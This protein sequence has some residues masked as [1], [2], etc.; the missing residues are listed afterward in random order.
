MDYLASVQALDYLANKLDKNGK[1]N[2]LSVLKLLFFAERYHARKY[3]SFFTNDTFY[4][5]K[6]G[7]VPSGA[8]DIL[9]FN[10]LDPELQ[11]YYFEKI[12]KIDDKYFKSLQT[13]KTRDDY[14]DL[15]DSAM[16]SLDFAL[17]N[18]GKLTHYQLVD[19][20]HRYPEWLRFG[21]L[22]ESGASAREFINVDDYFA[23]V[24]DEND[25][26]NVIPIKAVKAN[27]DWF[28]GNF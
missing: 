23:P 27:K 20:T 26:Y 5:M 15:S 22:L 2:K 14:E 16:E 8:K 9:S 19:E 4:A 1:A 25:P 28:K 18:F 3:G 21:H 6:L 10:P 13:F 24:I 17:Q 11:T 12:E 7:P